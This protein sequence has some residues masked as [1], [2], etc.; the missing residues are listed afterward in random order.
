MRTRIGTIFAGLVLAAALAGGVAYAT[1]PAADGAINGCYRTS[2]DDQKGQLRI[3]D[4]PASCRSNELAIQWSQEGPQGIQGIRGIQGIQGIQGETGATGAQ[5]PRGDKGDTG[6]T[7]APGTNGTDGIDGEDGQ[8]GTDGTNGTNGTDGVD[9]QDGQPGANGTNGTNGVDGAPGE[10]GAPCLPT[11]PA[12]VGPQG[13]KGDEGEPGTN[14]TNG[15][16]G[17]P[18]APCLPTT[19][20]CVGPGGPAAQIVM[21]TID[22]PACTEPTLC[23]MVASPQGRSTPVAVTGSTAAAAAT[24]AIGTPGR[25]ATASHWAVITSSAPAPGKLLT[26]SLVVVPPGGGPL[27][28]GGTTCQITGPA[29]FCQGALPGTLDVPAASRLAVVLVLPNGQPATTLAIGWVIG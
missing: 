10:P 25:P 29:T 5:G 11:N 22:V 17:A 1:I 16:N 24:V 6:D 23:E 26:V 27:V 4:D 3:V 7:G 14:G 20:A 8:P 13:L 18:G 19:P 2:L 28:H 12:C 9:G 15:V 21:G